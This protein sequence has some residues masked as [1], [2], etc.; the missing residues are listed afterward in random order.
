MNVPGLRRESLV[1]PLRW[2]LLDQDGI[3][4]EAIC[5]LTNGDVD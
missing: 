3:P 1:E 5:Y 4:P 2:M